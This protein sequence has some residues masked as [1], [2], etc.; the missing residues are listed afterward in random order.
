MFYSF[1]F[2]LFFLVILQYG[3]ISPYIIIFLSS[4]LID[5]DHYLLYAY[6]KK[7]LSLV[8]AW[9]WHIFLHNNPREAQK[10]IPFLHLFHTIEFLVLIFILSFFYKV[11]LWIFIGF[12]F[13]TFLDILD[14]KKR[15]TYGGRE[16]SL[17]RALIKQ[18]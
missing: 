17:I 5:I 13:H 14:M 6:R 9:K 2:C 12:I 8:K 15:K 1:I 11:F 16:Y 10:Q 4:I 18:R 3:S 7:N